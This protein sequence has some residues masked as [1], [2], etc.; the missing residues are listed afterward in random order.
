MAKYSRGK[1]FIVRIENEC[2]REIFVI[3]VPFDNECL[4]LVN[5]LT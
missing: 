4:L 5:Y 3:A 1:T 2:S